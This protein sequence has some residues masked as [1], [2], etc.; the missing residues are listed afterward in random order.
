MVGRLLSFWDGFLAGSMLVSG[1]VSFLC[2][3]KFHPLESSLQLLEFHLSFLLGYL[4]GF[5]P[6]SWRFAKIFWF[7]ASWNR[8]CTGKNPSRVRMSRKIEVIKVIL[9]L[10]DPFYVDKRKCHSPELRFKHLLFEQV[11]IKKNYCTT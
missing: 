3:H 4:E 9:I 11:S 7:L 10:L 1:S 8:W 2:F 6:K 5:K